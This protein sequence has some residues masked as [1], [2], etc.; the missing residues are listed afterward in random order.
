MHHW[1]EHNPW[2]DRAVYVPVEELAECVSGGLIGL[3]DGSTVRNTTEFVLSRWHEQCGDRLDAYI[4]PQPN[5]RHLLGVR[6]GPEGPQYL[7]PHSGKRDMVEDLLR[8]YSNEYAASLPT[9]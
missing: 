1:R 6:F 2:E 7:A 3:P 5:Q 4:L 9:P 8:R